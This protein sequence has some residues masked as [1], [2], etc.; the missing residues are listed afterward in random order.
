M[1]RSEEIYNKAKSI[2]RSCG[3]RDTLK[4]ARELGIYVHYIDD[5]DELLGM[6]TYRHKERHILLNSK[7]EQMIMQMVC[8]HEIGHD[9]FHRDLAKANDSLPEF[10]LFDMR[11]KHE[12]EANAFASHIIIDDDELFYYAKQGYDVVQ[13]SSV[14]ETNINLMLIKLNEMNRMGWQLNL[15][16]VPHSDFLKNVRPEG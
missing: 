4:I 2:V 14:L 11:T 9:V 16:Y 15:P 10:V 8:G 3:T 6:Y 12:Y 13:L 1:I 7:M 5:F